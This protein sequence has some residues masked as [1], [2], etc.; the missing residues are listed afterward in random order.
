M[1]I[2]FD[3]L[4][5]NY[6]YENIYKKSIVSHKQIHCRRATNRL[7]TTR[8]SFTPPVHPK[9]MEDNSLWQPFPRRQA[10]STATKSLPRLPAESERPAPSRATSPHHLHLYAG[11]GGMLVSLRLAAM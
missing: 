7:L 2:G 11:S 9:A 6:P 3:T 5:D 8:P 4:S 10:T 1:I